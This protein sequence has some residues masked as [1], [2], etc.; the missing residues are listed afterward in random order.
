V[1]LKFIYAFAIILV[2]IKSVRIRLINI[3]LLDTSLLGVLEPHMK[4]G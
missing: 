3:K 2:L 4:R 1:L